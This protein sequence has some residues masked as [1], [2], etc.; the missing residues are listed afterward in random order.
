MDIVYEL[1]QDEGS[2]LCAPWDILQRFEAKENWNESKLEKILC[3]L[4]SD[5]YLD[6]I[7]SDRKGD[8]MYVI[9]LRSNG[10]AYRRESLQV[11]RNIYFKVALTVGGAIFSF[12][13]GLLLRALFS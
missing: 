9:T 8:P 1:C 4:Q 13:I 12:L 11:K 3:D 10:F 6:L 7:R 5:G 2:C